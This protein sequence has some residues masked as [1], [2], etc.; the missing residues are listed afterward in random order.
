MILIQ[1]YLHESH[2]YSTL[3]HIQIPVCLGSLSRVDC[4]TAHL[5]LPLGKL[6]FDFPFIS[7]ESITII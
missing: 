3:P 1:I 6:K 7:D 4:L 5:I 2:F